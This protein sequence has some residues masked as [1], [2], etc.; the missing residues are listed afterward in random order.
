MDK[1]LQ[2]IDV[3]N[4]EAGWADAQAMNVW[5]YSL[6]GRPL[7]LPDGA[8]QSLTEALGF[9]RRSV[10]NMHFDE[11]VDLLWLDTQLKTVTLGLLHHQGA[12]PGDGNS[13]PMFR[14]HVKGLRDSDLLR[15]VKDTLLVQFANYVGIQLDGDATHQV[16]RCAGLFRPSCDEFQTGVSEGIAQ[17]MELRYRQEIPLLDSPSSEGIHRCAN[18][19]INGQKN[20]YCSDTCRFATLQIANDDSRP[21]YIVNKQRGFKRRQ[22][23]AE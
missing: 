15:V 1:G 18:F 6:I 16:R 22:K 14:A 19:F 23:Q 12:Q 17:E 8:M 4:A 3:L 9:M 21:A 5:L 2:W 7:N 11:P 10:A 20:S 13:L